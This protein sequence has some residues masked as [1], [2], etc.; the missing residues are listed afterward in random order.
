[1]N[2][3]AAKITRFFNNMNMNRVFKPIFFQVQG[4]PAQTIGAPW[5]GTDNPNMMFHDHSSPNIR[6]NR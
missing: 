2:T 6:S 5:A 3:A 1:M 4:D